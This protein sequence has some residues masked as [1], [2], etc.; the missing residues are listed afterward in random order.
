MASESFDRIEI[1]CS[2]THDGTIYHE[3]VYEVG[4]NKSVTPEL[5][6]LFLGLARGKSA[7]P[8]QPAA[9]VKVGRT[10]QAPDAAEVQV[11]KQLEL[12]KAAAAIQ[13]VHDAKEQ[14]KEVKPAVKQPQALKVVTPDSKPEDSKKE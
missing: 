5:A 4:P 3:G 14:G 6:K 10:E 1:V 13:A 12:E 7:H 2:I 8:F 11:R 9:G